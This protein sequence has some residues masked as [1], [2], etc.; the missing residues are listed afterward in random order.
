VAITNKRILKLKD[1][2]ITFAYK[3]SNNREPLENS[4]AAYRWEHVGRSYSELCE[5]EYPTILAFVVLGYEKR[6]IH[7]HIQ[8]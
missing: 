8:F 3:D 1:G 5:S 4:P 7:I 6:L 2:M